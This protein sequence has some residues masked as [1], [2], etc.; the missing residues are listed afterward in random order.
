M[1]WIGAQVSVERRSGTPGVLTTLAPKKFEE[2]RGNVLKLRRAKG[3]VNSNLVQKVAGQLSWAS[4]L[5]PWIR[6]FNTLLWGA[7]SAHAAEAHAAKWSN[8][9]RPTQLFF[10]VRVAQALEWVAAL[11]AGAVKDAEGKALPV[12]R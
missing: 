1:L 2:M 3:M 8:K 12:Q 6:S 9:K 5:F 4:G 10:V 7:L 11:L